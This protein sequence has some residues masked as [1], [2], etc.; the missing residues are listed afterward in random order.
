MLTSFTASMDLP[1]AVGPAMTSTFGLAPL[2]AALARSAPEA[3]EADRVVR[4]AK[5]CLCVCM[6]A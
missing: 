6:R 1:M 2:D 4:G 3:S 5:R